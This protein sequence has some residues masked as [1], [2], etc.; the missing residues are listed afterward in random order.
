MYRTRL[1]SSSSACSTAPPRSSKRYRPPPL[2]AHTLA[3][4]LAPLSLILSAALCPQAL[5]L[6][7]H[8]AQKGSPELRRAL[9]RYATAVRELTTFRC[10]P[11]PFKGDIPWKRVQEYAKEALDALHAAPAAQSAPASSPLGV[12][13]FCTQLCRHAAAHPLP[14]R[15]LICP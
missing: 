10:A 12:S 1:T 8:A 7:K 6:V 5:R 9:A 14:L 2:L 3:C 4:R 11:D 13:A 15:R